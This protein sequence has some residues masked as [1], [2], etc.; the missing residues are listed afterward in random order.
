MLDDHNNK[1]TSDGEGLG[2]K[3]NLKEVVLGRWGG[4]GVKEK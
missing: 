1:R 3:G 2:K 4:G